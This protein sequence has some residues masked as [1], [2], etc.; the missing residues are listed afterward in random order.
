MSE[1][2]PQAKILGT[3]FTGGALPGGLELDIRDASAVDRVVAEFSPDGVVHLAAIA[4]VQQAQLTPRAT[5]DVNFGGTLNLVEAMLRHVP[6]ARLLFVSSSE[7]Y[8]DSFCRASAP[9]DETVAL[10][11]INSYAASKAAADLLIGQMAHQGLRGIRLR[12]FNHTG[13]GQ[14]DRFVVASFVAQIVA[15]ERGEQEPVLRVGNLDAQ[16]DFLD[17]RDVVAAYTQALASSALDNGTVLNI[18]SGQARRI[19]D[20]LED[21]LRRAKVPIRVLVDPARLRAVEIPVAAGDAGRARVLLG[22]AP[23]IPFEQTLVD[24]LEARRAR[25]DGSGASRSRC[26]YKESHHGTSHLD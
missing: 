19:G 4:Q 22:W 10:D 11:P 6:Q 15:I 13:P 3:C 21:L 24:M 5:F 12:P 20:I 8:G 9:V 26:D 16:R 14:D 7:V 2:F 25:L 17:V 18:A 23:T 1:A